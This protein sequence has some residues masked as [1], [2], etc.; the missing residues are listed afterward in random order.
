MRNPRWQGSGVND[1]DD[2]RANLMLF[3]LDQ[4][5]L[6]STAGDSMTICGVSQ[7]FLNRLFSLG[8]HDRIF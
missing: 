6:C 8:F 2:D 1:S 5:E 3:S 7:V 4:E